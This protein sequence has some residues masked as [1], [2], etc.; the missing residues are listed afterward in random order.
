[1]KTEGRIEALVSSAIMDSYNAALR[2]VYKDIYDERSVLW[3]TT[4]DEFVCQV[5]EPMHGTEFDIKDTDG[6]LPCHP[7]CRCTFVLK[8]EVIDGNVS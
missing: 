3:W 8:S 4:S 5:C 1:M 7:Q 2:R 6:L